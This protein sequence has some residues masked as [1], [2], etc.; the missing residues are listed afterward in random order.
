MGCQ[1]PPGA[2]SDMARGSNPLDRIECRKNFGGKTRPA[3]EC[4]DSESLDRGRQRLRLVLLAIGHDLLRIPL[5]T[6]VIQNV[7][8]SGRVVIT[9]HKKPHEILAFRIVSKP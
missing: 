8:A 4:L 7:A 2:I 1:W 9:A 6:A 3:L 5:Q